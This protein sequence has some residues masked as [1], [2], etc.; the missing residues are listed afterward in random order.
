MFE[1]IATFSP[2]SALTRVD[3][4]TFGRP[5][6][7]TKPDFIRAVPT[8]RAGDRPRDIC[9]IVSV[10]TPVAD[11]AD[12]QLVEPLPAAAAR[13]RRDPDRLEV[14]GLYPAVA[15][16]PIAVFSAQ[17]PSGYAAFSTF[18]PENSRP[19]FVRTTAPTR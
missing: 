4:P 13:R 15:A 2:V 18:T 3:F 9:A 19:S 16:A 17:T 10:G 14:P 11:V 8:C 5:A 6:T 1:T 12:P 7:A